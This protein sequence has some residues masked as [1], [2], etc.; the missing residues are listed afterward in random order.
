MIPRAAIALT[1]ALLLLH[2]GHAT[3]REPVVGLPCENCESVFVGMPA[4]VGWDVRIGPK[5]IAGEPLVVEGTVR[6]RNDKPAAGVVI[7]AYH[8]NADGVYPPDDRTKGTAA[9]HQGS[10]RGW[11]KTNAQG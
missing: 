10:L 3:A 5:G 8:T 7:Y 6:D 2:S 11:A 1:A 4:Q 9:E